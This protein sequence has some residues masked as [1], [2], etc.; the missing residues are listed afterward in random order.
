MSIREPTK[1]VVAVMVVAGRE[2]ITHDMV[3]ATVSFGLHWVISKQGI[4][5]IAL[6]GATGA[7]TMGTEEDVTSPKKGAAF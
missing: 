6:P 1:K 3:L 5:L 2:S 4:Q 7:T